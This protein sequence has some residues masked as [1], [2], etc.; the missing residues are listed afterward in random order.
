MRAIRFL[1][2]LNEVTLKMPALYLTLQKPKKI[3]TP[4][5]PGNASAK[6]AGMA[7]KRPLASPVR[8]DNAEQG[9]KGKTWRDSD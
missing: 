3:G 9:R 4:T 2:S 7:K 1:P 6:D 8:N 5:R